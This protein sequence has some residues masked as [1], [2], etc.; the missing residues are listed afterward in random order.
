MVLTAPIVRLYFTKMT[1]Q[2][3]KDIIVISYNEID[4]NVEV[5]SVGVVG[6]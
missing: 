5:Q 1:E 4:S 2:M 6:I 3:T